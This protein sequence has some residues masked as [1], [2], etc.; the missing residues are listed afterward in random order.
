MRGVSRCYEYAAY[1]PGIS[2]GLQSAAQQTARDAV[3]DL[4]QNRLTELTSRSKATVSRDSRGYEESSLLTAAGFT[5]VLVCVDV[6]DLE[7]ADRVARSFELGEP[8]PDEVVDFEFHGSLQF[9]WATCLVQARRLQEWTGKIEAGQETPEQL[10][11]AAMRRLLP[12]AGDRRT[13]IA[14]A[15]LHSPLSVLQISTLSHPPMRIKNTSD[16]LRKPRTSVKSKASFKGRVRFFTMFKRQSINGSRIGV[17]G[18]L[19][20]S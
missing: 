8:A 11:S 10:R 6:G 13:S 4:K 16:C 3:R 15:R 5:N 17:T 19:R 1:T 7:I 18:S 12:E 9:G 20:T 14:Y 2:A